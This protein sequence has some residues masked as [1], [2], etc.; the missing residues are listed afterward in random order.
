MNQSILKI[1]SAGLT[2]PSNLILILRL[3]QD[4]SR[5]LLIALAKHH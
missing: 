3:N 5:L 2:L 1:A 4:L